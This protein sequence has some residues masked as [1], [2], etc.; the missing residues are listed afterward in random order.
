MIGTAAPVV[1]LATEVTF[2]EGSKGLMNQAPTGSGVPVG[3]S[4]MKA[5]L[6]SFVSFGLLKSIGHLGRNQNLILQHSLQS[7]GMV[8]GEHALYQMKMGAKPKGSLLDQLAQAEF[9]NLQLGTSMSLAH[10][11]MGGRLLSLEKGLHFSHSFHLNS[12]TIQ[13][14]QRTQKNNTSFPHPIFASLFTGAS[15]LFG[16][17]KEASAEPL[18]SLSLHSLG[19]QGPLYTFIK[20]LFSS[21]EAKQAARDASSGITDIFNTETLLT[22]GAIAVAVTGGFFAYNRWR[23]YQDS[24]LPFPSFE[25]E[26][27]VSNPISREQ[28]EAIL[29]V[30]FKDRSFFFIDERYHHLNDEILEALRKCTSNEYLAKERLEALNR[31]LSQVEEPFNQINASLLDVLKENG[32]YEEL[33]DRVS[34]ALYQY[35]VQSRPGIAQLRKMVEA[36]KTGALKV[37]FEEEGPVVQLALLPPDSDLSLESPAE[38]YRGNLIAE[39]KIKWSGQQ[40]V[41][42]LV[43]GDVDSTVQALHENH[44]P[45]QHETAAADDA[46]ERE[47]LE[48]LEG[49]KDSQ[50]NRA[51]FSQPKPKTPEK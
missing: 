8:A 18:G 46:L 25:Q 21:K 36:L 4:F 17:T 47:E 42:N 39:N 1:G 5:W 28:L 31:Y 22:G 41:M 37:Q 6:H 3:P 15:I 19:H 16:S 20:L 14:S 48:Y 50:K 45:S 30:D 2:F 26:S 23:K 9:T 24:T 44:P 33:K 10:H 34:L 27:K 11:F 7:L 13:A 43:L 40:L 35:I 51:E 49:L 12:S 38:T 32:L 29:F